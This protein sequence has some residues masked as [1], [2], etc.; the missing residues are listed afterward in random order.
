[1]C[2]QRSMITTYQVLCAWALQINDTQAKLRAGDWLMYYRSTYKV[3]TDMILQSA[4]PASEQGSTRSKGEEREKG[5]NIKIIIY[6]FLIALYPDSCK[7]C[8]QTINVHNIPVGQP[9]CKYISTHSVQY[10]GVL[11]AGCGRRYAL[12]CSIDV[13]VRAGNPATRIQIFVSP[14]YFVNEIQSICGSYNDK[15]VPSRTIPSLY[16]ACLLKLDE[17]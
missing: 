14:S 12:L 11:H 7:S 15:F 9:V 3:H 2:Y 8:I 6:P 1:M 5:N 4:A 17:L 13:D 16:Q 10:G